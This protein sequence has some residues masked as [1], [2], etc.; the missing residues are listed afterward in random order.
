MLPV[1][2]DTHE[3]LECAILELE[4]SLSVWVSWCFVTGL[5]HM[6]LVRLVSTMGDSG[7]FLWSGGRG[8]VERVITVRVMRSS[9]I[10]GVLGGFL[11]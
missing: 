11:G 10:L 6:G 8:D 1:G 4:G 9:K 7:C 2:D 3:G 5:W